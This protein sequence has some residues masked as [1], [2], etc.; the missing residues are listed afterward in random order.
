MQGWFLSVSRT[1]L[2]AGS[3]WSW[4]TGFLLPRSVTCHLIERCTGLSGS[5]WLG[6]RG[7]H[8]L[9]GAPVRGRVWD[10]S[11][12]VPKAPGVRSVQGSTLAVPLTIPALGAP[13]VGE[14][15]AGV[16]P[17]AKLAT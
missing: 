9:N 12:H 5:S 10:R 13:A 4:R 14:V 17:N 2:G 15:H 8:A 6:M 3:D 7:G 1:R 16:I 11:V